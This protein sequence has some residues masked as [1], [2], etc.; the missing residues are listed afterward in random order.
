MPR[1]NELRDL[2]V[3]LVTTVKATFRTVLFDAMDELLLI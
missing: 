1:K 2:T 3:A